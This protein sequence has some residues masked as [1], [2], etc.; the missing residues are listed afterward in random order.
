MALVLRNGRE[1]V[2]CLLSAQQLGVTACPLNTFATQ[3][4]MKDLLDN[5]RPS[6]IVCD[7]RHLDV[8]EGS[9][10]TATLVTVGP[11]GSYE[12]LLKKESGGTLL[13]KLGRS[14]PRVVIHTSGT[15]GRP[16]GASRDPASA[17]AAAL[18]TLLEIVPFRS[19]DAIFCP[20][21]MFHSFG[22]AVFS[23]A[24]VLG[25]HMVLPDK[26][27]PIGS[28][29]MMKDHATTAAAFI[30]VMMKRILD[31]PEDQLRTTHPRLRVVVSSGS[32]LPKPVRKKAVGYFG[33]V[34]YDLYGSTEAGW[35]S[36]ASPDDMRNRPDS[37]GKI[38]PGVEIKVI[39]T[40]GEEVGAGG[41][42]RITVRSEL[43]FEGYTGS[44]QDTQSD[45]ISIGDYGRVE[46]G[47]LY[48]HGR[49]DDMAVIGG[50]NVY[51][52]EVEALLEGFDGVDEAAV[53][54]V[55]DTEYGQVLKAYY[56]GSISE[57]DLIE[58][59]KAG[60]ASYKVPRSAVRLDQLPR[61][62][63]GKVLKKQLI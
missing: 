6:V 58:R 34:L 19:D 61:N 38:V 48:L 49:T 2:E 22:L 15:T 41:I 55:A 13:P 46:D 43:T 39:G 10:G 63:T 27:E 26:F 33:D 53:I 25:A 51:P 35:V 29:E 50:E 20:A 57:D 62:A 32:F 36:I 18:A 52:V 30:P 7:E 42:G 45:T 5:V 28:L 16:K 54:A 4:E 9:T 56:S 1:L 60:L 37:L 8:M 31:L 24:T 23:V 59:A 40:D 3:R 21:P 17:G 44:G 11:S 47:Y 14:S 12:P